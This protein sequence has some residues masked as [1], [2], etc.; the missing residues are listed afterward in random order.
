MTKVRL[1]SRVM[2]LKNYD[3]SD[4]AYA[5][6]ALF[7]CQEPPI[8]AQGVVNAL[9]FNKS[10]EDFVEEVKSNLILFQYSC[11]K[12]SFDYLTYDTTDVHTKEVVSTEIPSPSRV[13]AN[14]DTKNV[15]M[16]YKHKEAFGKKSKAKVASLPPTVFVYNNC[17]T[18]QESYD[19]IKDKIDY[20][21][22]IDRIYERIGEFI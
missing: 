9:I 22:Y 19:I 21:Y 7:S 11:R 12:V 14:K 8:V 5:S 20:Q 17:V 15:G 6:S 4:R 13:F 18:S 1:Y 2:L 3:I 16:V 10:P